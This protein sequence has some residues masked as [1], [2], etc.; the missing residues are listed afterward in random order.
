MELVFSATEFFKNT[1][2]HTQQVH[3]QIIVSRGAL[4]DDK[5][6]HLVPVHPFYTP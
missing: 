4:V 6:T 2:I 3:I 5:L 1:A